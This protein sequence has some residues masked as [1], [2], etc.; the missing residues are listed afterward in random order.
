MQVRGVTSEALEAKI[1]E[2]L[3]SQAGFSEELSAQ[4]LIVP[5]IDLTAAAEGSSVR[6]ELQDALAFGSQTAFSV[7]N[8]NADQANSP[9]FYRFSG[10]AVIA[11]AST[12]EFCRINSIDATPTTKIV[13]QLNFPAGLASASFASDFDLIFFLAA[14]EKVNISA[15]TRGSICG[16]F[17]Q[18]ANVNGV[19]VNPSGFNPQ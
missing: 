13:W 3:P 16:S 4:N 5:I 14:G 18:I 17:R 19:S 15:S 10:T 1:R 9:G 12:A 7:N 11:S 2:L 8:T 6:A